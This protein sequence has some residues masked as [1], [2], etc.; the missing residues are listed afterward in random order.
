MLLERQSAPQKFESWMNIRQRVKTKP[1]PFVEIKLLNLIKIIVEAQWTIDAS[2]FSDM[3]KL[4]G[5]E[6]VINDYFLR[7]EKHKS[8]VTER[9]QVKKAAVS[10][11]PTSSRSISPN[12]KEHEVVE[13]Q[14]LTESIEFAR[15][16]A[17]LLEIDH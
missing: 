12:V 11:D 6:T 17:E 7:V 16:M 9:G 10:S 15:K 2:V 3:L 5:Y 1:T 4:S 14:V 13:M 8:K